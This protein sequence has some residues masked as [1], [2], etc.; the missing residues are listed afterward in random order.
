MEIVNFTPLSA[1]LGGLLIGVSV[2]VFLLFNGRVTGI[3]GI[4]SNLFLSA[5]NRASN[6][7]FIFGLILGPFLFQIFSNHKIEFNITNSL[8]LLIIGGL[9]VGIGTKLGSGCTSGHAVCGLARFSKRS[10]LATIVFMIVAIV[11]V[12]IMSFF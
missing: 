10:M 12:K 9:L 8:P 3:S 11:T 6:F 5:E 2:L 7:L 4:L 1:L